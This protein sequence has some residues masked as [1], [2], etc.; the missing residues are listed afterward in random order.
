MFRNRQDAGC[1]LANQ[2][3]AYTNAKDV[4]VLGI[5][6]GGVSVA[7][8]IANALHIPM[9]IFLSRKLGVPGYEEL[10]FGAITEDD[11]RFLD[12]ELIHSAGI[13]SE[14][15]ERVIKTTQA[16]LN[17]RAQLYR[18]VLSPLQTNGHVVILV[19][20][21]I[22]TGA[23]MV[24]AISA[25]RQ[26]KPKKLVVAVPVAPSSTCRWLQSMVD[27]LV[28]LSAPHNFYAVGQ[29]YEYFP[30]VSDEEVIAILRSADAMREAKLS[31]DPAALVDRQE[32]S[33]TLDGLQLEG[34]LALPPH[35]H[36]IV[37]FAHGSGSSRHS[38]RNRSVARTLNNHGLATLL[39]DLLT[40]YEESVDRRT[41]EFRFNIPLL[42]E[43]LIEVT[44]WVAR[45]PQLKDLAIGYFGASSGAAAALVAAARLPHVVSAVVSRGGRPD[46]AT[47]DLEHLHAHTLLLVGSLDETVIGLN[48]RALTQMNTMTKQLVVI[49]GATH[50]FEEPGTLERVADLTAQ[51]MVRYLGQSTESIEGTRQPPRPADIHSHT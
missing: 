42:A 38:P 21:G 30:Q 51:W 14:Q 46:L 27:E 19:D 48:R 29:F 13:S 17:Q 23:S 22:A 16:T 7:F 35:P 24:A 5:P 28:V 40:S 41:A 36:G 20:D 1:Q 26:T 11:G 44:H 18:G 50:L 2:L 3:A 32:V 45:H 31:Y 34:T 39:F 12:H 8:E 43:R 4:V 37:I 10:A 47:T 15:V 25:L 9:D 33:I 6:R 49:P